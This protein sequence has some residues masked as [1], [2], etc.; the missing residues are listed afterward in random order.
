MGYPLDLSAVWGHGN[1]ISCRKIQTNCLLMMHLVILNRDIWGVS[2]Q[3][4]AHGWLGWRPWTIL[5]SPLWSG[6]IVPKDSWPWKR[7][8]MTEDGRSV[9]FFEAC[10]WGGEASAPLV[11][12]ASQH[13]GCFSRVQV[14][15]WSALLPVAVSLRACLMKQLHKTSSPP[16]TTPGLDWSLL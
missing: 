8:R 14:H 4:K 2:F 1:G 13:L 12:K 5:T 3:H 16:V 9:C 15:L 11:S 10:R 6:I 7:G